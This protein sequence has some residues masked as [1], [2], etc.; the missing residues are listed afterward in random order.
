MSFRDKVLR[1]K[2]NQ[3]Y[4]VWSK[5]QK[6]KKKESPSGDFGI[7]WLICK[8]FKNEFL[9]RT[10]EEK[11]LELRKLSEKKINNKIPYLKRRN[12]THGGNGKDCWVCKKNK[13]VCQHHIIQLQNG[14][15]DNGINR[16][17]I[18]NDCHEDIHT[19][20]KIKRL[21]KKFEEAYEFCVQKE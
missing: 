13:A 14:G 5:K 17:P 19:F 18:C 9:N 7:N 4:V 15:F 1:I 3:Q 2:Y 12:K 10:Y 11:I 21:E 8:E 6:K 20:L 16:I